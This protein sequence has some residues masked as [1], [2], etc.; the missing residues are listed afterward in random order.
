M[1]NWEQNLVREKHPLAKIISFC[2]RQSHGL[3]MDIRRTEFECDSVSVPQVQSCIFSFSQS[4]YFEVLGV[5]VVVKT[6]Y[7]FKMDI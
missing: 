1:T 5:T 6:M 4:K 2:Q 3:D 7:V